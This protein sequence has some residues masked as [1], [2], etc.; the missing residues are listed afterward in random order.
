MMS[1][2]YPRF[3]VDDA[4]IAFAEL[5][6]AASAGQPIVSYVAES[7]H[8]RAYFGIGGTGKVSTTELRELRDSMRIQLQ[9]VAVGLRNHDRKFDLLAG[10][11][12]AQWFA[13]DLRGQA[14]NPG[15]WSYLTIAVLP[16]LALSRFPLDKN[17]RLSP[18]RFLA[19]RRNVFYRAYLR[20]VVL[21]ELLNDPEID[22]FEDDLVGLID[23]N[24]SADHRLARMISAQIASTPGGFTRRAI[25]REGLKAVQFESRVTDLASLTD[26]E[27]QAMIATLFGARDAELERL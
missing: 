6:R 26:T 17:G 13:D 24:I 12:L 10:A 15:M 4:R 21:G 22:L 7:H 2:V 9:T 27:L 5:E 11:A 23:R 8:P 25:V 1:S 16:D 3:T 18:E 19:G 14:A 20:S